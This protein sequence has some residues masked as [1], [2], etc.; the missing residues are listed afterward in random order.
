M[1]LIKQFR[2]LAVEEVVALVLE[3]LWPLL[4]IV[5]ECAATK[6]DSKEFKDWCLDAVSKLLLSHMRYIQDVAIPLAYDKALEKFRNT[7]YTMQ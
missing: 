5:N 6:E 7:L 4:R 3:D 2:Q 1:Q